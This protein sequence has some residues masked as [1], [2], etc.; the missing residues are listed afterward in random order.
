MYLPFIKDKKFLYMGLN[1]L[2]ERTWFEPDNEWTEFFEHKLAVMEQR[3]EQCLQTLPSAIGA[4]QELQ[5]R[6]LANLAVN[7]ASVFDVADNTVTHR[8]SG[9]VIDVGS[10]HTSIRQSSLLVQDDLCLMQESPEGYRLTAA[11]LCSPSYWHLEEK[12]G[13]TLDEIHQPL[14]GYAEGLSDSMNR[15][16]ARMKT[17]KP[18]WRGNW[19][20]VAHPGLMQRLD[21]PTPGN[22]ETDP[23]WFRVERQTL[24]RLPDTGA[25]CFTIRIHRYPLETVISQPE[26]RE[27][28][29]AAL[30]EMSPEEKNYKSL[31]ELQWRLQRLLEEPATPSP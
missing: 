12:I 9:A 31:A 11:S 30:A 20:I 15:F 7:H 19:S 13:Q 18:V 24:L 21:T 27:A 6:M 28:V 26:A 25:I 14:P 29:K 4:E 22:I 23:L 17:G 16:F 2:D 3:R 5:R 8:A 10:D 1:R